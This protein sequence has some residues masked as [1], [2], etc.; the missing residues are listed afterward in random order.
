VGLS[1]LGV[2]ALIAMSNE[3]LMHH[4]CDTPAGQLMQVGYSC[5]TCQLPFVHILQIRQLQK[6]YF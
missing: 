6:C 2:E 5:N 3:L 4:G 1:H